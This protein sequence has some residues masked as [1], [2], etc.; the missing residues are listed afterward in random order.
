MYNGAV[1]IAVPTTV[2]PKNLTVGANG[3]VLGNG[4]GRGCKPVNLVKFIMVLVSIPF[5]FR[6][7]CL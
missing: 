2:G 7:E 5:M 1:I 6:Y 3:R 4:S